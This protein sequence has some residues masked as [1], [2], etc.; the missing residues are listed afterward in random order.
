MSRHVTCDGILDNHTVPLAHSLND[1]EIFT[2]SLPEEIL[3]TFVFTS[4]KEHKDINA[5]T[6]FACTLK[7]YTRFGGGPAFD[8]VVQRF[9]RSL[10]PSTLMYKKRDMKKYVEA[11]FKTALCTT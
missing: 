8:K 4:T 6:V 7:M 1:H 9:G 11:V 3:V 5:H 10:K 2:Q